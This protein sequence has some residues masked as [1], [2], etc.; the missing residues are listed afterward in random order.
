MIRYHL[1]NDEKGRDFKLKLFK[2]PFRTYLGRD[3]SDKRVLLQHTLVGQIKICTSSIKIVK[4]KIFLFL[5]LE[6]PKK[7]HE[8]KEHIIAEASL[9]VEYPI[10]VN[11]DRDNYQIGN[12][13]EFLYRLMAIQSARHR[14]QKATTFNKGGH[15][16]KKKL[17]S[18]E[19][20]NEKEK[21][22]VD[23][24]LHLYSRRLI[25]I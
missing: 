6:P 15:G 7:Q 21:R 2:I 10:T 16:R 8:L 1:S 14:L 3:R 24:H 20:F 9:S 23:S 4:G 11:I 19:H 25:D 5:A 13:E 17:K 22:Y 18:L 12:K